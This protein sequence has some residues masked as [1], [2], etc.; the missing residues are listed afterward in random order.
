MKIRNSIIVFFQ[1]FPYCQ[2]MVMLAVKCTVYKF[3]LRNFMIQ[4]KL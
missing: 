1:I 4:E 3:N 2:C